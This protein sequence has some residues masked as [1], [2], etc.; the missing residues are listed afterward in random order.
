MKV[1]PVNQK[2]FCFDHGFLS[3]QTQKNKEN[4]YKKKILRRNKQS[5]ILSL[6]HAVFFLFSFFFVK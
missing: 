2:H 1:F 3:Y 4:I 6:M 5:L